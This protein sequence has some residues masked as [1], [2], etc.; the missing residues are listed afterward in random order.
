MHTS[1]V[2]L[3]HACYCFKQETYPLKYQS[4]PVGSVQLE[5]QRIELLA[6]LYAWLEHFRAVISSATSLPDASKSEVELMILR[7]TTSSA[8]IHVSCA[9]SRYEVDYD[10]LGE[11]FEQIVDDGTR[12][13][14]LRELH[15][16]NLFP[17]TS[18]HRFALG[19]GIIEPL[20]TTAYKYR[21][22]IHRRHAI[23]LLS[24]AGREGPWLGAREACITTR[25]MEL[26][27][28]AL[29]SDN[30]EIAATSTS[31]I[32]VNT[33]NWSV[34]IDESRRISE[35]GIGWGPGSSA[36]ARRANARFSWYTGHLRSQ[37]GDD[38]DSGSSSLESNW[39]RWSEDLT[40]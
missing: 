1:F 15:T 12:V 2:H 6:H 33:D 28:V 37:E 17:S 30:Q 22:P 29:L 34:A 27:E 23:K 19:P 26:E 5:S 36:Y 25:L 11:H 13:L 31:L 39:I 40:F 18:R 14:V 16:G 3:I 10:G 9:L 7:L 20:F 35:V 21:H 32:A 8:L 4:T 38:G 24:I